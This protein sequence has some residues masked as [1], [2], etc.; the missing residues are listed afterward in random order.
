MKV[1]VPHVVCSVSAGVQG[2]NQ[3]MRRKKKK[4]HP[5]AWNSTTSLYPFHN[6]MQIA[7]QR[8]SRPPLLFNDEERV[9]IWTERRR[10]INLSSIYSDG[11]HGGHLIHINYYL[12]S[13]NWERKILLEESI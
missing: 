8:P 6:K 4:A 11:H 13:R 10:D 1:V 9:D 7:F 2:P 12:H 5:M 3:Q